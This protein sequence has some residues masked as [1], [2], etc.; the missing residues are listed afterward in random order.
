[1]T[2]AAVL[3]VISA[4]F[5]AGTVWAEDLKIVP[6]GPPKPDSLAKA[7]VETR[8][9]VVWDCNLKN[10]APVIWVHAE[11]GVVVVREILGPACGE[12]NVRQ[13]G[14]FYKSEPGFRGEDKVYIAGFL[15]TGRLDSILRVQVN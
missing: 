9:G 14:V 3:I 12:Q 2:R 5:L 1:M 7:G 8:V 6:A 10:K 15:A 4:T 13:A 11:H